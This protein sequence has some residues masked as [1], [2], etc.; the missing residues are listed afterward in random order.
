MV[1]HRGGC[2]GEFSRQQATPENILSAAMGL[3][4]SSAGN[5]QN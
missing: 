2:V 1:L 4:A 5:F 3:D